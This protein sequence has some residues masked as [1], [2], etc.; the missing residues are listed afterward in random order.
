MGQWPGYVGSKRQT[1]GG[2]P[3]P[4]SLQPGLAPAV[5]EAAEEGGGERGE[6]MPAGATYQIIPDSVPQD[7][8]LHQ[9]QLPIAVPLS[10][11]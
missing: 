8:E 4:C 2:G 9:A 7:V 6:G 1:Q 5:T 10:S 11:R 3:N